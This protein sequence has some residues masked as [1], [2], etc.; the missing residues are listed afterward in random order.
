MEYQGAQRL[1]DPG[2]ASEVLRLPAKTN[3]AAFQRW[4]L[5]EMAL[6]NAKRKSNTYF[7]KK[8]IVL[9]FHVENITVAQVPAY[10]Q[11]SDNV[12]ESV[13]HVQ[14]EGATW[15]KMECENV[16]AG[17][18][19]KIE[20][21]AWDVLPPIALATA[22]AGGQDDDEEE[23]PGEEAP[24]DEDEVA[25]SADHGSDVDGEVE[26]PIHALPG[27]PVQAEPLR[28]EDLVEAHVE[29]HP[30][31]LPSAGTAPAPPCLSD[32]AEISIG[33]IAAQDA[34]WQEV[35]PRTRSAASTHTT[36]VLPEDLFPEGCRVYRN[37]HGRCWQGYLPGATRG[38]CRVWAGSTGRTE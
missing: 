20:Q 36:P 13:I 18:A 9:L 8:A 30:H 2:A 26:D 34:D 29:L 31:H 5:F 38:R 23:A 6:W 14:A 21:L 17:I 16:D 22:A 7:H 27:Q 11:K 37:F 12:D 28:P 24:S 25:G 4:G 3:T 1:E 19:A 33:D 10:L 15:R 35:K 32:A